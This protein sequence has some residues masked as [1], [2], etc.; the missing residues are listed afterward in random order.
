[1]KFGGGYGLSGYEKLNDIMNKVTERCH[2]L[3]ELDVYG[4]SI[5]SVFE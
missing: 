4:N 2:N 1:M 3:E 5:I